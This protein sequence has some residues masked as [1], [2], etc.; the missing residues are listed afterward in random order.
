MENSDTTSRQG[1]G[2][3]MMNPIWQAGMNKKSFELPYNGGTIWCEHL[4]GMA[5]MRMR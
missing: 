4:D 2:T 1:V 5:R 3:E